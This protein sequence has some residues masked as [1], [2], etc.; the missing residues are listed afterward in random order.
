MQRLG[1][2]RWVAQGGDW[3]SLITHRLA[4]RK[5]SGLIAAHVNLPLVFPEETP[6]DPTAEEQ[7]V[8][9]D[10]SLLSRDGSA[11]AFQQGTRPQTLSYG[12]AD[13]PVAQAMWIYEKLQSWSDNDGDVQEALSIDS[14]LD[15]I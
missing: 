3:G 6:I 15:D 13:S 12:L 11:Y 7:K 5:P 4:Q 2:T 8:L 1:Y 14:M 9:E 10:M